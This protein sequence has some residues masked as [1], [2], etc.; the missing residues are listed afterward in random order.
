MD[1]YSSYRWVV[2][3]NSTVT[4]WVRI[5]EWL[6]ER[7]LSFEM[8]LWKI[9]GCLECQK[10]SSYRRVK[11]LEWRDYVK[12][13]VR[14][15]A[16]EVEGLPASWIGRGAELQYQL[17]R[18]GYLQHSSKQ[19][20]LGDPSHFLRSP[21]LLQE[22]NSTSGLLYRDGLYELPASVGRHTLAA[23]KKCL[24]NLCDSGGPHP[25]W[26]AAVAARKYI[27]IMMKEDGFH[28]TQYPVRCKDIC[29]HRMR[30]ELVDLGM[31]P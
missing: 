26:G 23:L 1:H 13:W 11:N 21:W 30:A 16:M 9:L 12:L 28:L 18:D 3:G 10:P 5:Q 27:G 4:D 2:F 29:I 20:C 19:E 24:E 25:N 6:R 31:L 7:G 22:H 15:G 14:E 8:L 17:S